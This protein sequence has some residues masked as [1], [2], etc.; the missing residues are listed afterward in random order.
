[1]FVL[2]SFGRI[3][4]LLVRTSLPMPY[5]FIGKMV[6]QCIFVF[7]YAGCFGHVLFAGG[8]AFRS[9]YFEKI[10]TGDGDSWYFQWQCLIRGW[11][12]NNCW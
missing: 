12:R 9:V 4:T 11:G 8:I 3:Y 7:R 6:S 5:W 2:L 1:M 10:S